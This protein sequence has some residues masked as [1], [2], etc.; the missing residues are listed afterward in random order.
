MGYEIA[1]DEHYRISK[2]GFS[3]KTGWADNSRIVAKYPGAV[4]PLDGRQFEKWLDDAEHICRLHND[5][6]SKE[7]TP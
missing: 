4:S 3:I 7:Q 6:L 2:S 5:G 1:S